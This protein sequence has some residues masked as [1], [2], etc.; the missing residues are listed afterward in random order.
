MYVM[1]ESVSVFVCL[2]VVYF[3][4]WSV[5]VCPCVSVCA[6]VC[7]CCGRVLVCVCVCICVFRVCVS[8]VCALM[9]CT[10]NLKVFLFF[11]IIVRLFNKYVF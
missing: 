2:Y 9:A 6:S 8:S 5:L 4:V 1:C 3:R 10:S 11:L 7:V